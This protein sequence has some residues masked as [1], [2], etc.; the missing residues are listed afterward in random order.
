[1]LDPIAA[2]EESWPTLTKHRERLMGI[3]P[4]SEQEVVAEFL[5]NEFFRREF[6]RYREHFAGLVWNPDFASE[7]ENRLRRALLFLR[8]GRLWRELPADTEWWEVALSPGGLSSL[9]V[10]PRSH[11]LRFAR[12]GFY[13][14]EMIGRIAKWVES[15]PSDPFAMKIRSLRNSFSIANEARTS[16]ILIG[17]KSQ[18]PFT[19]IEG[20]HRMAAC[21]IS[22]RDTARRFRFICGFSARMNHCCWYRTNFFTLCRYAGNFLTYSFDD[23][24]RVLQQAMQDGMKNPDLGSPSVDIA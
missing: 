6:D 16:V 22:G 8:R 17:G 24:E 18:G 9:R 21:L 23:H 1:M 2:N 5:R 12:N 11:W 3:R 10:F 19:I 7:E 20:N 4:I 15:N 14:E 13:L